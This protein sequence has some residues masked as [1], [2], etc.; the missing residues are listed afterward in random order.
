M[1]IPGYFLE[2]VLQDMPGAIEVLNRAA[3]EHENIKHKAAE[4]K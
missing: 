1:I 4:R 2:V 3:A